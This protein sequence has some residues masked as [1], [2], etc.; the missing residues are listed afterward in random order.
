MKEKSKILSIVNFPV[1][2]IANVIGYYLI[3][4]AADLFFRSMYDRTDMPLGSA[5]AFSALTDVFIVAA[6]TGLLFFLMHTKLYHYA[7]SSLV[8]PVF[9]YLYCP[10][11]FYF[12]WSITPWFT[13]SAPSPMERSLYIYLSFIAVQGL[14]LLICRQFKKKEE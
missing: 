7:V 9:S 5:F 3:T 2:I 1:S 6:S 12:I 14:T 11:G 10:N 13:Q 8:I 4:V